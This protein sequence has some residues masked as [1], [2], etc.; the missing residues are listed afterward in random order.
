MGW[1][2]VP[3]FIGFMQIPQVSWRQSRSPELRGQMFRH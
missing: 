2:G 3:I 1:Q